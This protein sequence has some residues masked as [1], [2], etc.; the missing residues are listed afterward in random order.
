MSKCAV[1]EGDRLSLFQLRNLTNPICNKLAISYLKEITS[2][3]T[4]KIS[5]RKIRRNEMTKK[6]K[7]ILSIS[8]AINL[9]TISVLILNHQQAKYITERAL[10]NNV[11]DELFI[12]HDEIA[13]QEVNGFKDLQPLMKRLNESSNRISQPAVLANDILSS[14]DID[15]LMSLSRRLNYPINDSTLNEEVKTNIK[16]DLSNLREIL[17]ENG[18]DDETT[19]ST[20]ETDYYL[21]K[22]FE[23]VFAVKM[24]KE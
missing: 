14:P 13:M 1:T 10:K 3:L 2:N 15:L 19:F 17:A 12:I 6:W 16:K 9:L 11:I 22:V 23:I 18:I 7:W 4:N 20:W 21:Y 8:I 24:I 5:N